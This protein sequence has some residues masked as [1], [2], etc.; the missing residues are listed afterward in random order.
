MSSA[1][2]TGRNQ[3]EH[4]AQLVPEFSPS[5]VPLIPSWMKG[6]TIQSI[7]KQQVKQ[8]STSLERATSPS[9][10]QHKLFY[11]RKLCSSLICNIFHFPSPKGRNYKPSL[12]FTNQCQLPV[13]L[14]RSPLHYTLIDHFL[15]NLPWTLG[16]LN[17]AMPK[18]KKV[19]W[20]DSN[21]SHLLSALHSLSLLDII[22]GRII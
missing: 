6:I 18:F 17:G 15:I 20:S 5:A 8:Q 11:T 19:F 13:P 16:F 9:L 10:P 3:A 12:A 4:L 2:T 1:T 7:T 14:N 21:P 22:T